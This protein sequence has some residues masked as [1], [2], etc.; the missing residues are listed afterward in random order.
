MKKPQIIEYV[1]I[2]LT[3]VFFMSCASVPFEFGWE[4]PGECGIYEEVGATPENSLI[5]KRIVNPCQAQRILATVAKV[6]VIWSEVNIEEFNKWADLVESY[7][8]SGI[9]YYDIQQFVTMEIAKLNL[10]VGVTLLVFSDLLVKFPDKTL[11]MEKD[12]TLLKMSIVDIRQQVQK[13]ALLQ[14]AT[15]G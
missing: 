12:Q 8:V 6:G 15:E 4:K 10:K 9:T 14:K 13:L 1:A 2:V 5:A 7:V 11:I 3:A